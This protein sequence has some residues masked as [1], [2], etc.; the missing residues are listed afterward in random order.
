MTQSQSSCSSAS[1]PV[2]LTSKAALHVREIAHSMNKQGALVRIQAHPKAP[3]EQRYELD[4]IERA[5]LDSNDRV[6]L[7]EGIQIVLDE[8]TTEYMNGTV[9]D[10]VQGVW[11]AG[12]RFENP[13]LVKWMGSSLA[14]AVQSVS[15]PFRRACDKAIPFTPMIAASRAAAT[16]PE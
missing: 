16:V 15:K 13:N 6:D 2:T 8:G 11:E 5:S 4:F 7:T 10:F 1:L 3:E 9:M 12:F 14:Q